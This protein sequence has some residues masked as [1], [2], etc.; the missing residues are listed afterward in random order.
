[1][2]VAEIDTEL[3][4]TFESEDPQRGSRTLGEGQVESKDEEKKNVKENVKESNTKIKDD[5]PIPL[6]EGQNKVK[7]DTI[8]LICRYLSNNRFKTYLKDQGFNTKREKLNDLSVEQLKAMLHRIQL[9]VQNR[10]SNLTNEFVF[11][12]LNGLEFVCVTFTADKIKVKGLSKALQ[13]DDSFLD[14]LEEIHLMWIT[15][16]LSSPYERV[17]WSIFTTAM[18]THGLNTAGGLL[19]SRCNASRNGMNSMAKTA[20][21]DNSFLLPNESVSGSNVDPRVV[22]FA[23]EQE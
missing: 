15:D 2:Q 7:Q 8:A 4:Y 9:A 13:Q 17:A 16:K 14:A 18:K 21:T 6:E 1:M 23:S 20:S 11:E 19:I 5:Y 10:T 12:L 22:R 3:E